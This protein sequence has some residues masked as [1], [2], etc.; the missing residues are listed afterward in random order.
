MKVEK[1]LGDQ[2]RGTELEFLLNGKGYS[3]ENNSWESAEPILEHWSG[4]G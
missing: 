4:I 2:F 3:Q 1:V